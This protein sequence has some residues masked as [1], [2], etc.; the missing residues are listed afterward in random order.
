[1]TTQK[2]LMYSQR[3]MILDTSDVKTLFDRIV[4]SYTDCLIMFL[5]V[6]SLSLS[7]TSEDAVLNNSVLPLV[8]TKSSSSEQ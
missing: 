6:I 4:P 1:M 8:L 2:D 7:L 3:N 5:L